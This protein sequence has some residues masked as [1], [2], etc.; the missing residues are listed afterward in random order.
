ISVSDVQA[1]GYMSEGLE[2][3]TGIMARYTLLERFCSQASST[4]LA[5]GVCQLKDSIAKVYANIL[6][7][8]AKAK[9]YWS[10]RT[11]GRALKASF[12]DIARDYYTLQDTISEADDE[13]IR[14][15]HLIQH[16]HLANE[17][18]VTQ[19]KLDVL[20]NEIEGSFVRVTR[21]ITQ[22]RDELHQ[23]QRQAVLRWLST[24]GCEQDHHDAIKTVLDG[25]GEWLFDRAEF[26][27]WHKS[28]ASSILWLHG[29]PGAGK[30]KL[31][32]L[33]IQKMLQQHDENPN[34]AVPLA[35][36]Y[37]SRKG[38]D[39]R[40]T[41]PTEVLRAILRQLTG[42]RAQLPLRG[43]AAHE[44]KSRKVQADNIGACIQPLD[45]DEAVTQIL[46]I[47]SEDPI[48]IVIDALDELDR[49]RG[50]LLNAFDE[51]VQSSSNLVKIF[52]SS[53]NDEDISD[54][55]RCRA[56][57]E[58]DEN[59]NRD[60]MNNFI[61]SSIDKAIK[62]KKMLQGKVSSELKSDIIR[63]LTEKSQG[64]WAELSIEML[65]T[66]RLAVEKDIRLKLGQLPAKLKDQYVSIHD[67]IMCS[68]PATVSIAQKTFSWLLTAQRPLACDEH[69]AAVALDDDGYYHFDLDCP[70][71]LDICRNLIIESSYDARTQMK[72][73]KFAHLSVKEY[74]EEHPAFTRQRIHSTVVLRCLDNFNPCLWNSKDLVDE[75]LYHHLELLD[76][77]IL[78][79]VHAE[80]T[81]LTASSASLAGPMRK[82]LFDH[83]WNTSSSFK[84][85]RSAFLQLI[86]QPNIKTKIP[87]SEWK[88]VSGH[89]PHEENPVAYCLIHGLLGVL[90][91]LPRHG[92][93]SW[94]CKFFESTINALVIAAKYQREDVAR[95]LLE[96]DINKVDETT[97]RN[98]SL[99]FAVYNGEESLVNLLLD[100]GADPLLSGCGFYGTPLAAFFRKSWSDA[101]QCFQILKTIVER[102]LTKDSDCLGGSRI[103]LFNW[104]EEALVI[105]LANGWEKEEQF[106]RDCGG[107]PID[108]DEVEKKLQFVLSDWKIFYQDREEYEAN[109]RKEKY[110][111][112]RFGNNWSDFGIGY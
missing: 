36:F 65:S 17:S 95:W 1:F 48:T 24:I 41:N 107:P 15:A 98:T 93:I 16:E 23:D 44:Y 33:V 73:F 9:N 61:H 72:C 64:I 18:D 101:Q 96:N 3:V 87:Y 85:W 14:L 91:I 111:R 7:F 79:F 10:H 82:F 4:L 55:Y 35:F 109:W 38:T 30:S 86:D 103:P 97:I 75:G 106:L 94:S 74:F 99:Y 105:T 45:I 108:E 29:I 76:Y 13:T 2:I 60:D 104:K 110:K 83:E 58:I 84:N 57:I 11:I 92:K 6:I 47:T 63:T 49:D 12:T 32:S 77:S 50:D 69:I 51:I 21:D 53:R 78:L 22:L 26:I 8:L 42:T 71:L 81:D 56:N 25:T 70:K 80:Y 102:I 40:T 89:L 31:T 39:S 100:F 62:N 43:S 34:C 5:E 68:G 88:D 66:N 52:V 59:C 46:T 54:R 20:V 112:F 90:T 67:E 37:C 28:S 27:E 19:Q